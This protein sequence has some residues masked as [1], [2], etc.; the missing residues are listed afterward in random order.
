MKPLVATASLI[1]LLAI[2]GC[3]QQDDEYWYGYFKKAR[4]HMSCEMLRGAMLESARGTD[5]Y[6]SYFVRLM[7]E[8]GCFD[9]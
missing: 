4:Q 5:H 8:K 2:G 3:E 7:G 9:K 1:G 6:Q